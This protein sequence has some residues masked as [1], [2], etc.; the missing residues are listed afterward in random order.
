MPL[1]LSW[2]PLPWEGEAVK[3]AL[4]DIDGTLYPAHSE[5]TWR[6]DQLI[7][8]FV[9]QHL[10]LGLDEADEL[11]SKTLRAYGSTLQGLMHLYGTDPAEYYAFIT[12]ADPTDYLSPDPALRE[13][14]QRSTAKIAAL[15]NAPRL[16]AER[17]LEALGVRSLFE[18]VYTIEDSGHLGKPNPQTY[19]GALEVLGTDASA[20]TMVEDTRRFLV[21]AHALGMHT[22]LV[23]T[24][25]RVD[26]ATTD[27]AIATVHDLPDAAPWLFDPD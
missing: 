7:S 9:A 27:A 13:M 5:L 25:C 20:V 12:Q 23:G 26:G 24:H 6:V 17:V 14:L 19:Q 15:T 11:R 22:V 1:P 18:M 21:P 16:H 8:E 2:R 3:V 4:F 10:G